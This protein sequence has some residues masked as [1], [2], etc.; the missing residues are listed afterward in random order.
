MCQKKE[1]VQAWCQK[2]LA[3]AVLQFDQR[4]YDG[5]KN[6]TKHGEAKNAAT[7]DKSNCL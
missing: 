4:I 7:V 2:S 1:I 3:V 6:D 5:R